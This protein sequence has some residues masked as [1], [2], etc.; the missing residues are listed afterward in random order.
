MTDKIIDFLMEEIR[1]L[2]R[3]NAEL[4]EQQRLKSMCNCYYDGYCAS[5]KEFERCFCKGNKKNCDLIK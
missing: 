2:W 3:E 1:N 4:K 5:T